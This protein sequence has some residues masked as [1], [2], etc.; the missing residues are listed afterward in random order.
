MGLLGKPS[1]LVSDELPSAAWSTRRDDDPAS[2]SISARGRETTVALMEVPL[3]AVDSGS[4]SGAA[5]RTRESGS[6]G[7]AG[8][9][10]DDRS[11]LHSVLDGD[12][13]PTKMSPDVRSPD[14]AELLPGEVPNTELTAHASLSQRR[15]TSKNRITRRV[16]AQ[17]STLLT[18]LR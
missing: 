14:D 3:L 8:G 12:E 9:D 5:A 15:S 1:P 18:A 2:P 13:T 17:G 6:I 10:V 4:Q 11:M 16:S 7:G